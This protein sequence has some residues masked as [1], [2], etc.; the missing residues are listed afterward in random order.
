MASTTFDR[1]NMRRI[2]FIVYEEPDGTLTSVPYQQL[3]KETRHGQL[4]LTLDNLFMPIIRVK[5][6]R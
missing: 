4:C 2:R 6:I 3:K 5:G 1:E